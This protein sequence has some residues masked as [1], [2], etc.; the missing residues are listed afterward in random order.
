MRRA[1]RPAGLAR[2]LVAVVA[3]GDRSRLLGSLEVP[4]LVLHGAADPLV[5]A[6]AA[7]DLA[8][9]IVGATLDLV[10]GMGHDL[11]MPL[12]PRFVRGIAEAAA[13]A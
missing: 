12:L 8:T 3:D 1:Y 13:R 6:A 11:P 7:H 4:T 9:K 10:D 5:P 2:Q